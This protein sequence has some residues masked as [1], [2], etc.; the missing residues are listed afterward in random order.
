MDMKSNSNK[1]RGD[2]SKNKKAR[3]IILVSNTSS[4]PVLYFYQ[5]SQ[6]I[7]KGIRV[8]EWTRN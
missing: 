8:T 5:E 6:N 3:V 1:R 7:P 2:N 4:H